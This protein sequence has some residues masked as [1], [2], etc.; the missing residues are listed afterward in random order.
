MFQKELKKI[1][2]TDN[3]QFPRGKGMGGVDEISER[4]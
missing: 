4:D 1:A 2:S 3:R